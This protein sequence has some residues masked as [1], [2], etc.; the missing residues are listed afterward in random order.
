MRRTLHAGLAL[1]VLDSDSSW[2]ETV[3]LPG[4]GSASGSGQGSATD[5]QWG[6]YVSAN[7]AW[8]FSQRWNLT[9]GVQYQNLGVYRHTFGGRGVEVD[10]SKSIFVTIGL[11]YNF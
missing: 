5:V 2:A 4:I 9:G 3:T 8:Q 1:A 6:G 11:G 10:L 7:L